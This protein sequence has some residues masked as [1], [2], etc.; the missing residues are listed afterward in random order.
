MLDAHDR[1]RLPTADRPAIKPGAP[2]LAKH[3][4]EQ[5]LHACERYLREA[6]YDDAGVDA[7]MRHVVLVYEAEAERLQHLDFFKP[8]L[9]WDT[10]RADRFPRKVD[11]SLEEARRG[12]SRAPAL[13]AEP[14]REMRVMRDDA[15]RPPPLRFGVKP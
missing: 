5:Q 3:P 1:L 9:I 10:T 8:A 6:G 11:T 4:H 12:P 13:R 14:A 7:K 15:D 2:D